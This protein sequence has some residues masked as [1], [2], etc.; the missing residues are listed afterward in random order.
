MPKP[1]GS[2]RATQSQLPHLKTRKPARVKTG[3]LPATNAISA[4]HSKSPP[5]PRSSGIYKIVCTRNGKFYIGSAVCLRYRW[6]S[7]RNK[8]RL[9]KHH[10]RHLQ[11]A[12]FK[13]REPAFEFKV[14]QL[15]K[16]SALL[17]AEQSWLDR[18]NCVDRDVGFNISSRADGPGASLAKTWTGF[19]DPRGR[20]VTI[21]NMYEFCRKK[22]LGAGPMLQLYWGRRKLKSHKGWTHKNSV[23][24]RDYVKTYVGFI[25][26][27]GKRVRKIT[28]LAKFSREH[29]LMASHMT[30]VARRRIISHRGWTHL[31][32]RPALMPKSYTG[33]IRPDGRRTVIINLARYCRENGL[34]KVDMH[35]LKSGIRRI[36]KG[37]TWREE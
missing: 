21:T 27:D 12:W 13:Y 36:H 4:A 35:N 6:N 11:A 1:L 7:H 23:R 19:F 28:N 8:L 15:V 32:G 3:F 33:F 5:I 17:A 14:M 26:P 20:S 25:N 22:Q 37:W 10:N 29:G 30:A 2:R 34:S 31:D 18:S 16:R 24:Q 9:G